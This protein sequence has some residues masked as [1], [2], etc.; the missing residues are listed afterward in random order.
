MNIKV[1]HFRRDNI[2]IFK[3]YYIISTMSLPIKIEPL[4]IKIILNTNI[5][6][7]NEYETDT[8]TLATLSSPDLKVGGI[9][10]TQYPYFTFQ[11]KYNESELSKMEYSDIVKTFFNKDDLIDKIAADDSEII[12]KKEPF[13]LSQIEDYCK[14]RT[15]N[16]NHNVMIMLKYIL[17]TRFPVINNQYDSFNMFKGVDKLN[18]LFYDPMKTRKPLYLKLSGGTY[19]L[20]KVIWLNDVLNNPIYK[21]IMNTNEIKR[22]GKSSSLPLEKYIKELKAQNLNDKTK[23]ERKFSDLKKC[24]ETS[25]KNLEAIYTGIQLSDN[26]YEIH[27]DIELFENELKPEDEGKVKCPYYGDYLGDELDRLIK[28]MNPKNK[29]KKLK[30]EIIKHPLF[31]TTTMESKTIDL[32]GIKKE[33][34]LDEKT[35][36]KRKKE[37][38]DYNEVPE[39]IRNNYETLFKPFFEKMNQGNFKA[40]IKKFDVNYRNFYLDF[41]SEQ[42]ENELKPL[43]DYIESY[44]EEKR[45]DYDKYKRMKKYIDT[46]IRYY[47][48]PNNIKNYNKDEFP[49]LRLEFELT[50]ELLK[51]KNIVSEDYQKRYDEE[52][53]KEENER[54]GGGKKTRRHKTRRIKKTRKGH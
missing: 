23:V 45:I 37:E 47:S 22:F 3:Y 48:N 8:L 40:R 52:K 7:E 54:R 9:K 10:P 1:I 25:C 42:N 21:K 30:G 2:L 24:Y 6:K 50:K 34:E 32:Y 4:E 28:D 17:P 31:S 19:T 43:F 13:D 51:D 27:I 26:S 12:E 53:T 18:T 35:K 29:N 14:K 16:I 11:V 38:V 33:E 36:E 49:V 46:Q 39:E 41:L 5:P 20:K 15:E 44:E